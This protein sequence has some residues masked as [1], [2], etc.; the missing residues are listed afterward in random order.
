ME[1]IR[2]LFPQA[3]L[4][5]LNTGHLVQLEAPNEFVQLVVK[6]INSGH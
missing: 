5:F 6:F 1:N 2:K 3:E 4:E